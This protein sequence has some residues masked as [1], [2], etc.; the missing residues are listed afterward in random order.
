VFYFL[1]ISFYVS[2]FYRACLIQHFMLQYSINHFY[3]WMT[4][5]NS[6][7]SISI[8]VCQQWTTISPK[9]LVVLFT[10]SAAWNSLPLSLQHYLEHCINSKF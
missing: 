7:S 4:S 8:S 6:M 3:D 10:S 1:I 5:R 9:C 2:L